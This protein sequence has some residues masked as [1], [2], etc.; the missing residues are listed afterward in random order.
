MALF[1]VLPSGRKNPR[2]S[3]H[4]FMLRSP[5]AV[6]KTQTEAKMSLFKDSATDGI[7]SPFPRAADEPVAE[8]TS[9]A[10]KTGK[11]E[12]LRFH[13]S[14]D[15]FTGV[16]RE[17]RILHV[18]PTAG[19]LSFE[20][21]ETRYNVTNGDYVILPNAA[22]AGDFAA[23][24][25]FR[26]LIF[27]LSPQVSFHIALRS[28]YGIVGHLALLQNP[29]MRLSPA[30]FG[31][32]VEDIERL[33][34]RLRETTH[35]FHDELVSHLLAAHVLDLYDIHAKTRTSPPV[36]SRAVLLLRRFIGELSD[37]AF[38][39]HRDLAWYAKKL[40]VTPEYLSEVC[41]RVSGR[42]AGYFIDLF[43]AGEIARELL[44]KNVPVRRIA[45]DFHFSSPS[46]FTRYVVRHLGMTP[47]AFR[48]SR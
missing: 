37:G 11:D 2:P 12:L 26:A 21:R 40:F 47:L 23:S 18:V 44:Q 29:V 42:S 20:H 24:V 31:R 43:T 22:L 45:E 39:E 33:R 19:S 5:Y 34:G 32:C 38:R 14:V 41:R 15:E 13:D 9:E 25:D 3:F 36:S 48:R 35:L 28:D 30:A 1:S 16:I 4:P 8:K 6:G 46:Y 27:S 10:Q 7:E 17:N